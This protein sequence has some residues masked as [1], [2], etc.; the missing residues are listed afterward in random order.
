MGISFSIYH[1][2]P[3]SASPLRNTLVSE[4]CN[5]QALRLAGEADARE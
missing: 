5:E 3:R 4:K 2:L 1:S